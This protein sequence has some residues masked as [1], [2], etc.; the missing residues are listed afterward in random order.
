MET[1]LEGSTIKLLDCCKPSMNRIKSSLETPLDSPAV[2]LPIIFVGLWR[3]GEREGE[4][5]RG[6]EGWREGG[7]E[8]ASEEREGG[9][10]GR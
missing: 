7:R 10:E 3:E 4:T 9:R 1:P 6:R 5:E 2:L 8:G